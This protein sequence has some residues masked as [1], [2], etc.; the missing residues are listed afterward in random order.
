MISNIN[1]ASTLFYKSSIYSSIKSSKPLRIQYLSDLHL[2]VKSN[3]EFLR[4]NPLKVSGD[5]LLIA[6]DTLVLNTPTFSSHPFWN[7]AS[8]NFKEVFVCFGNREFHN[9]SNVSDFPNGYKGIIREDLKNVHYFYNSIINLTS[10]IDLIISTLWTYI[11]PKDYETIEKG[12]KGFKKIKYNGHLI[13]AEEHSKE[14]L[15]CFE[16]LKNAVKE[17]KAKHKIIMTH[18]APSFSLVHKDYLGGNKEIYNQAYY[19]ELDEFIKEN[20]ID[21][22]IYGHTHRN[23]DGKI[24]NTMIVTNQI[25]FVNDGDNKGFDSSKYILI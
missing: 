1:T 4:K 14:Y 10:E 25:G 8:K 9:F 13:K 18:H 2:E 15:K 7:W 11:N 23:V 17:S 16:F 3:N 5:I 24:G 22:C 19:V 21:Y 6:G 12:M 20:K